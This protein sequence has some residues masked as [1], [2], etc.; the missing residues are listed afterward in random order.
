MKILG[1]LF[2]AL[3]LLVQCPIA[4][5]QSGENN[6]AKYRTYR[7][8]LRHNFIAIG[9]GHGESL[10]FTTRNH[11]GLAALSQ[12]EGPIMLG[13]YIGML[14]TEYKLLS[15]SQADNE[16]TLRELYYALYAF[17]RLDLVADSTNGYGEAPVLDGFF[18]REDFPDAFI[19]LHPGLNRHIQDSTRFVAGSGRSFWVE[20]SL[21]EGDRAC[22]AEP[23]DYSYKY[24]HIPLSLDQMLGVLLGV[25]LVSELVDETA[26]YQNLAFQ[27]GE[28]SL[29]LE[30]RHIADRLVAYAERNN[31]TLREPDGEYLGDCRYRAKT[32]NYIENNGFLIGYSKLIAHIGTRIT[33]KKYSYPLLRP[34]LGITRSVSVA[35]NQLYGRFY[36]LRMYQEAIVLCDCTRDGPAKTQKLGKTYHWTPFFHT[37]GV[38]LNDWAPDPD[39]GTYAREMLDNAPCEGPFFHSADDL[40]PGGWAAPHRFSASVGEQNHGPKHTANKGNYIGLDYLLLHNLYLLAYGTPASLIGFGQALQTAASCE[41]PAIYVR[42]CYEDCLTGNMQICRE[43]YQACEKHYAYILS[44]RACETNY[45]SCLTDHPGDKSR[46][47]ADRDACEQASEAETREIEMCPGFVAGKPQCGKSEF[48]QLCETGCAGE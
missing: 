33:G 14:A 39:W 24:R 15:F 31:W 6:V 7:E 22:R 19:A 8:R 43:R 36:N 32:P 23:G 26:H 40:A 48:R 35:S 29:Q 18:V 41:A 38:I 5:S 45:E 27:D 9:P 20:R 4:R 44:K 30:A 11:N 34:S 17:N 13:N 16:T 42:D 47:K 37:L 10:P 3:F 12:G 28:T 21:R 46:C 25:A 1:S 2:L